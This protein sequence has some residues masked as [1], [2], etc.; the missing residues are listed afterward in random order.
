M[1][2]PLL[3]SPFEYATLFIRGCEIKDPDGHCTHSLQVDIHIFWSMGYFIVMQIRVF[4]LMIHSK[5]IAI[6][7]RSFT[8]TFFWGKF[9]VLWWQYFGKKLGI[10]K[11]LIAKIWEN[12]SK[13]FKTQKLGKRK[14]IVSIKGKNPLCN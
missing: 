4:I 2:H 13:T 1:I 9:F 6:G 11:K 10:K 7:Q 5:K 3:I 14:S 12:L 8:S